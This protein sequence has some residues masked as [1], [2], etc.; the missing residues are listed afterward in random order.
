M[1]DIKVTGN[2]K[3][4]RLWEVLRGVLRLVLDDRT[5]IWAWTIDGSQD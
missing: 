2:F 5:Q 1:D 3:A 4:V